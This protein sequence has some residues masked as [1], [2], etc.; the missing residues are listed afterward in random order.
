MHQCQ[1]TAIYRDS[2]D[3]P[4]TRT[5]CE[6]GSVTTTRVGD[7]YIPGRRDATRI[8]FWCEQCGEDKFYVLTIMQHKGFTLMYWEQ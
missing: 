6:L 5:I 8:K 2:E 4:G 3:G 1:T 7:R